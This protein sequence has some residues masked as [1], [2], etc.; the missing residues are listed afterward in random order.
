MLAPCT[1]NEEQSNGWYGMASKQG[2]NSPGTRVGN[3]FTA[4]KKV[5]PRE[6]APHARNKFPRAA[7]ESITRNKFTGEQIPSKKACIAISIVDHTYSIQRL[8]M[9]M[10]MLFLF[11]YF[12]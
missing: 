10:R 1:A 6:F 8:W 12:L 11:I 4:S 5:V 9:R 3:K 7:G 2:T